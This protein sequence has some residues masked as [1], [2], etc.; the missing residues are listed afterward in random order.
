MPQKNIKLDINIHQV[1]WPA[2]NVLA[3]T[4]TRQHSL[5]S[6]DETLDKNAYSAF[7]LGTHVGDYPQS[8]LNNRKSL[9]SLL[10]KK[11]NIQWF[12][13]VHG[14]NVAVITTHSNKTLV[15]DAAV[16]KEKHIALAIMTA[17]CLP[18][19]L[20]TKQGN[21]IAAIHGGW[22]PLAGNIIAKTLAKMT[23][24]NNDIV[25]WLGP[26]I[27]ESAFEVGEEVKQQ[28]L[29]QSLIFQSA[30][31]PQVSDIVIGKPA[32]KPTYLANLQLIA[33]LQLQQLGITNISI[34]P[35][36]TF[37]RESEYYSYRRDK[38]T[39]RMATV[40]CRT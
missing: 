23:A 17:D 12:E 8:V 3:F 1:N 29:Q 38:V 26:C 20:S 6:I 40:I 7:N 33:M 39:G 34:L 11:S 35:H 21:E 14:N 5:L 19:L 18:I 36:C 16:T 25:A 4:T 24:D 31:K 10:P 22:R 9:I 2:Q 37:T 28:F 15:A 13:Q 30:F 32:E 27:G